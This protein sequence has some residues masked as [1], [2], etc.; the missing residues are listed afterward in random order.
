MNFDS[1]TDRVGGVAAALVNALT[2]GQE[3]G[4]PVCLGTGR[5]LSRCTEVLGG[6]TAGSAPRPASTAPRS[7]PSGPAPASR[8]SPR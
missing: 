1:Y 4:R 5:L 8:R 6:V 3:G 2:P 7:P